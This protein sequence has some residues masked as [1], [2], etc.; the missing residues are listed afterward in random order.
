MAGSRRASRRLA[1]DRRSA[2]RRPSRTTSSRATRSAPTTRR[3]SP[4]PSSTA[5]R[6]T[7]SAMRRAA[8]G[9]LSQRCAAP[10]V[11]PDPVLGATTSTSPGRQRPARRDGSI[12]RSA[13]RR[14]SR[15]SRWPAERPARLVLHERRPGAGAELPAAA[16]VRELA[17]DVGGADR[18]RRPH[19]RAHER[20]R[21]RERLQ[22]RQRPPDASTSSTNEPEPQFGDEAWPT[23]IPTLVSL[24]RL[25][26]GSSRRLN[27]TTG[28]VLHRQQRLTASGV[29]RKWT[30]ITGR[31]TYSSTHRLRAADSIDSIDSFIVDGNVTFTGRFSDLDQ[32]GS[33]GTVRS[34]GRLRRRQHTAPGRRVQLALDSTRRL[35]RRR[36]RSPAQQCSSSSR[37]ATP[38]A[39]AVTARTRAATSTR[40]RCPSQS[41]AIYAHSRPQPDTQPNQWFT[42]TVN[43][44]AARRNRHRHRQRRWWAVQPATG[45]FTSPATARTSSRR[46]A[47]TAAR[48]R[49]CS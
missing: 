20:G 34:P 6:C 8:I 17:G 1:L 45:P 43:V 25:R 5:C 37:R 22:P 12:T 33:S 10:A 38:P 3:R 24:E 16:A 14:S 47:P 2:R 23:K 13:V 4:K 21:H 48:R 7:A 36:A 40:S 32:I 42:G 44:T 46:E 28:P 35:V 29:E 18:A 30:H 39:T 27:L 31:V 15:R 11:A 19:R 9:A 41:G 26:T 49:R